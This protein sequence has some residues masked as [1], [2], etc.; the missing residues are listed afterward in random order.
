MSGP[1]LIADCGA[2]SGKW[3]LVDRSSGAVARFVTGPVNPS[4]YTREQIDAEIL[5]VAGKCCV[6][7]VEACIYAAGAIG[8]GCM[9]LARAVSEILGIPPQSVIVESDLT[10]AAKALLGTTRGVACI[11]GTGSNSC[12]WSGYVIEK[13]MPPMGYILG[14]EGSGASIGAALLRGAIR[15]QFPRELMELWKST[16]PE[17][18]YAEVVEKVYR[19]RCGSGYIASFVAFAAENISHPSIAGIVDDCFSRFIEA[20]T[21]SYPEAV[22]LPLAFTGGVASVFESRLRRVASLYGLNISRISPDPLDLL[23][24]RSLAT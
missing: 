14:D 6:A 10:G 8:E 20:V 16:Y 21:A 17:L 22:R 1:L 12:L 15:S 13:N 9:Q 18:T 19:Q 23:V 24:A 5:K 11:L 3:A 7:P 2:T 4:V